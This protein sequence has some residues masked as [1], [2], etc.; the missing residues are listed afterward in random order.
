MRTYVQKSDGSRISI[1]D[2]PANIAHRFE[3][4][5]RTSTSVTYAIKWSGVKKAHERMRRAAAPKPI[6]Y[7][8]YGG[9]HKQ[10]NPW[11][12]ENAGVFKEPKVVEKFIGWE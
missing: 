11:G 1:R 2:I 4:V 3:V 10:L 8:K 7:V 12:K 9:G 5:S 6:G